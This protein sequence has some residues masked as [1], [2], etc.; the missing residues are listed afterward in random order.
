MS[1]PIFNNNIKDA[2]LV[3]KL[4]EKGATLADALTDAIH[5]A[6]NK[7]DPKEAAQNQT[8]PGSDSP[9]TPGK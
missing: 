6:A 2:D 9:K 3:K 5:V 8:T 4:Q 1:S 7:L